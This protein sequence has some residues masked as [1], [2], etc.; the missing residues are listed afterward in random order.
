MK[1]ALEDILLIGEFLLGGGLRG[2]EFLDLRQQELGIG[3]HGAQMFGEVSIVEVGGGGGD[4]SRSCVLD[5]IRGSRELQEL[6]YITAAH[7]SAR[8]ST[9]HGKL[10]IREEKGNAKEIRKALILGDSN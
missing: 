3:I 7:Y 10:R 2:G 5:S 6:D 9:N 8:S 4:R 1:A